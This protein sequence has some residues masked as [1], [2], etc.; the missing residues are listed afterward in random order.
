M[1]WRFGRAWEKRSVVSDSSSDVLFSIADS[2]SV[3]P[4]NVVA[5]R[6]CQAWIATI[7]GERRWGDTRQSWLHRAASRSHLPYRTI[8]A[9][10]YG[11]I[12]QADHPALIALRDAA[13][14]H[15]IE[16]FASR[17]EQLA[18]RIRGLLSTR[19]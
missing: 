1:R 17:L 4:E 14:R 9:L 10:Y 8:R 11:E 15:E 6:E 5:L 3:A 13:Q 18:G 7:A 16:D 12:K 19:R 2:P